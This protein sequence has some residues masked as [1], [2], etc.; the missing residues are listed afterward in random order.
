MHITRL[1]PGSRRFA[2]L[3]IVLLAIIGLAASCTNEQFEVMLHV[4]ES[5]GNA[6]VSDLNWDDDLG[7]KAQAWAEHLAQQGYLSHS[8]LSDGA[9]AGWQRLGENVGYGPTIASVHQG[10]M[11]S[12]GH[13]ANILDSRF[14]FIGVGYAKSGN[15]VYTVQVFMKR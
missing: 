15:R 7:E 12:S 10:Y 1:S 9:P 3:A 6:G 14:N 5:R 4:N 11:N 8:N 13:R 2:R